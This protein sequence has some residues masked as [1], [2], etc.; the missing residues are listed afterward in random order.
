MYI[1]KRGN[2]YQI[3]VDAGSDSAG[4]RITKSCTFR[5]PSGLT[6]KQEEHAL[7]EFAA[8]FERQVKQNQGPT[9]ET[10]AGRFLEKY[11]VQSMT[12]AS[13][14][15]TRRLL[16]NHVL[17][18][19]G[20]HTLDKISPADVNGLLVA[21][22]G[23]GYASGTVTRIRTALRSVFNYARALELITSNPCDGIRLQPQAKA[24]DREDYYTVEEARRFLALLQRPIPYAAPTGSRNRARVTRVPLQMQIYYLLAIHTGARRGELVGLDWSAV[25]LDAGTLTI[26]QQATIADAVVICRPKTD[27]GRAVSVPGELLEM[28]ERW[29]QEQTS[30]GFGSGPVFVNEKNGAR[31]YPGTP[32]RFFKRL[33]RRYNASVPEADRL[34]EIAL[35]GLRH[36]SATLQIAAGVDARTVAGR[37][38]HARAS[39]TMD[40]YAHALRSADTAASEAVAGLLRG[41]NADRCG[42]NCGQSFDTTMPRKSKK[43]E[44]PHKYGVFR[45]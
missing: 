18:A 41:A 24:V 22:R 1:R 31:M 13:F 36:T 28:M 6:A 37:L 9:L 27:S 4:R 12:P 16:R 21:L 8:E 26:S 3:R 23:S 15:N 35:H 44:N 42:Q 2:S 10:F 30:R 40:I 20:A 34:P 11:A 32:Y 43:P 14:C 39:T 29:K 7:Q 5:P 19:L 25:D 38:G 17:P 45:Q 33:L